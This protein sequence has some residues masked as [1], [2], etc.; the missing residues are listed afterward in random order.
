MSPS[1]LSSRTIRKEITVRARREEVWKAWSTNAGAVDFFAPRANI[2]V[3]L[4]GPYEL[5]FDLEAPLGLQGSE[6]CCV[7][8][9]LPERMVSF[10]WNAPPEFRDLRSQRTWV[11][12]F[13]DDLGERETV[14][15]LAHLG[16]GV[17]DDW[18]R[19]YDYVVRAWEVVLAR[20]ERSF[21][22]GPIDWNRPYVPPERE[23]S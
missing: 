2:R 17:G 15:R 12:V 4:G 14:V 9:Y 19:L 18:D 1:H 8:S 3:E 6:G 21:A 13:L 5:F 7:L 11:V 20:L 10:E 16:W 23:K 22:V